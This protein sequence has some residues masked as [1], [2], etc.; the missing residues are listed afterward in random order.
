MGESRIRP[1]VFERN[2]N[3]YAEGSCLVK[4]GYT[5][6]LC[7][8]SVT[9]T[10]PD[11][12]VG[13]GRGWLTAEYSMLPRATHDRRKRS[14]PG[15]KPDSRGLE[16]QRL[17]GRSLRAAVETGYFG[18]RTV[19]IDCDVLQ[20]D[21][22]TRTTSI[23]GGMLAL[24]DAMIWMEDKGLIK[25]VPLVRMI[26]AISVGMVDGGVAVDLDY[27]QDSRAEV[28][29]NVVMDDEGRFVELQGTAEGEPFGRD[30]LEK[31]IASAEAGI[32]EVLTGQREA[33]GEQVLRR[34]GKGPRD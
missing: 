33:L 8:A 5:E 15:D 20:A 19:V 34:I 14:R 24:V 1:L 3:R 32:G 22:G 21:G 18:E 27:D 13:S 31:F 30:V 26:G 2:V 10:V 11:F 7:T 9:D 29:M 4:S 17:I 25:G 6:V 23:N 12:L 16:I 28:D